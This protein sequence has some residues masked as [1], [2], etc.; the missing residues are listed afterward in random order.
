M[1]TPATQ[2]KYTWFHCAG[3]HLVPAKRLPAGAPPHDKV[4]RRSVG[5]LV[6]VSLQLDGERL[7]HPRSAMAQLPEES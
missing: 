1:I 7:S 2:F 6:E 3:A 5:D 4:L